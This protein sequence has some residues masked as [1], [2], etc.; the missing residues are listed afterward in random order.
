MMEMVGLSPDQ[1]N[2]YPHQ[3]SGGQKQRIS[4]AR[5][6]ISRP[7]FVV[8]DKCAGDGNALLLPA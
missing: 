3:F 4:I 8:A 1:L 2:R 7:S 5:A 6:L